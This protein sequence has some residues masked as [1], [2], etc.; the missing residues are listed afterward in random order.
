MSI[1]SDGSSDEEVLRLLRPYVAQW[2]VEKYGALTPPQRSSIPAIKMGKNVLISSP[3]GSGK[4][5]AAFLGILDTLLELAERGELEDKIYAVYISP[6]RALNNDMYKNLI[7]PLN[8]IK[9]RINLQKEI[10][11]GV[12]TSDTSQYD[13]QK[14]LRHPPHILITTPE[15]FAISLVSPKFGKLLKGVKWII[16]DEIH[17]L[18][19]S[20]RGSFLSSFLELFEGLIADSPPVRI[21]LSATISPLEEVA[22]FL[23]G[24]GREC[25]IVDA[26]FM[27]GL[28]LKVISPVKDLV[29]ATEDEVNE[30][31]YDTILEEVKK[32][33]TTLIFTNTRSAAERV[34]Y[35]LRKLIEKEKL[36]DADLVGAHHSSLSR[37]VRLEIENKLKN[38]E[39]KVVVSSTSLEL[40]VDIGY[41][42]LVLLLSSPKSVSR[43]LQRIGRAGHHI[44]QTSKGRVIVVDRDDLVECSV[45]TKLAKERKID[46][47]HIPLKPLDVLVQAILAA[48]LIKEINREELFTVIKRSYTFSSLTVEE[49]D[50]VV[51]YLL[52]K[53]GLDSRNIYPKIR[54]TDGKLRPKRGAR[55]IFYMNSGTIPDESMIPVFT[56]NNKYVGNLEEEF[57]E[58]LGPGDVFILGGK[59]FEFLYSKGNKIVVRPAEGQRPTVPSWFSE[60]L[61]LAIESAKEISKF[62]GKVANMIRLGKNEREVVEWI[63]RELGV[64]QHAARS[65]YKYILEE[66]L[67]TGGVIPN[68]RLILVEIYDDEE[69]RRNF[70]FHA[71]FGRRA[72]DALSRVVAWKVGNDLKVDVK[73]SITDNGFVLTIPGLVDYNI[74]EAFLSIDPSEMYPILE[75]VTL[76]TEMIKRRF[77]HT[78]ERSLMLLRRYKGRETSID[79]RQ[80]NSETLLN[81][82]KE[83]EGFP[84]LRETFREILEDYMDIRSATEILKDVREGRIEVKAIG[85]N[86]VPSPFAH[87][88]LAKEYSDIVLASDKREFLKRMHEKVMEFLKERGVDLNLSYTEV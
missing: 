22:K 26:R 88:I 81:V 42:D 63:A 56:D 84:I 39:L 14:M 79:R 45:L 8:E 19:S 24:V 18:A 61:P 75:D 38:G 58:I 64:A 43:L 11:V 32:H 2:F 87:S 10:R 44:R 35:K 76:R 17:E 21:G 29:D 12:R 33:R 78:A 31:I 72:L 4:T 13:K 51:D 28:D 53:Y 25:Q 70:I 85:P 66:F 71:L 83:I 41:I 9:G 47:I 77:R 74:V 20:K 40:G 57:V 54:D 49:F 34:S 65:I 16:I 60:M 15:S 59:T 36:F 52:G 23:V 46:N 82:V 5:L 69:D 80:L 68:E 55:M 37:D 67:F 7:Q 6:L 86:R 3:T 27:K 50:Q 73:T 30:G 48:T 1:P 62:R